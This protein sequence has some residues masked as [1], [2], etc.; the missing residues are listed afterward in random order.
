MCSGKSTKPGIGLTTFGRT[1]KQEQWEGVNEAL[2]VASGQIQ[3]VSKRGARQMTKML[4]FA[5]GSCCSRTKPTDL[6]L[7]LMGIILNSYR[8]FSCVP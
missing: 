4:T 3:K 1:A 2:Q 6:P 8:T 7:P 5:A